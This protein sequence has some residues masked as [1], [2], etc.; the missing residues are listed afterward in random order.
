VLNNVSTV[1]DLTDTP[2]ADRSQISVNLE[3]LGT[4]AQ[5]NY[6]YVA[7]GSFDPQQDLITIRRTAV[8]MHVTSL[9]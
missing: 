5:P 9:D 8:L 4:T 3:N 2:V 6:Q 7:T 1:T